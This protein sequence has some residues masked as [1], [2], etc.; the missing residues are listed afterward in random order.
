MPRVRATTLRAAGLTLIVVVAFLRVAQT[1]S[2]YSATAD[3]PQ[4][5]AAGIEWWG[6]TDVVQHE[7]WRTVNPPVARIAVGLGPFLAGTRS[8]P[9]LRDTLYTGQGYARNLVTGIARLDG[10]QLSSADAPRR[11][12]V[13]ADLSRGR[14]VDNLRP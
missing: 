9:F 8:T 10:W 2:V 1:W 12:G 7:P 5:I 13:I 3:E 11:L 4:H 6:R 14:R